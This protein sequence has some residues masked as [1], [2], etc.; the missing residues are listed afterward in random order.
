MPNQRF[1]GD[2]PHHHLLFFG[3][4]TH[5]SLSINSIVIRAHLK[6]QAVTFSEYL[7]WQVSCGATTK[8]V[9]GGNK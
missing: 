8:A 3:F 4:L 1:K 7:L 9:G 5:R 6:R 2:A